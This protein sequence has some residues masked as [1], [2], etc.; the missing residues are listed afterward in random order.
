MLSIYT[1]SGGKNGK[2]CWIG[3]VPT[4]T[5]VSYTPVQLFKYM[6]SRHFRAIP[7][8]LNSLQISQFTHLPSTSFLCLLD[9]A[10]T[11]L[12]GSHNL[13]ISLTDGNRFDSLQGKAQNIVLALKN[14][15]SRA[16][17]EAENEEE[18]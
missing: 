15:N 8:A 3:E 16:A 6:I 5:V 10:P 11:T 1:K 9:E 14:L 7:Q 18:D 13:R 2:H 17:Q 4:I 12:V